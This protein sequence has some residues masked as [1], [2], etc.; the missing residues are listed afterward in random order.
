MHGSEQKRFGKNAP[1]LN[2]KLIER[3]SNLKP[4]TVT[5]LVDLRNCSAQNGWRNEHKKSDGKNLEST[6][7]QNDDRHFDVFL[8]LKSLAIGHVTP[9]KTF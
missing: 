5:V 9:I 2:S 3:D 6:R 7:T 4:Q 1:L 8:N